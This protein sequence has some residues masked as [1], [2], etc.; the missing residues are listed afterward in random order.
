[1]SAARWVRPRGNDGRRIGQ[2]TALLAGLAFA[3]WS[4]HANPL[5]PKTL[6]IF[7]GWPSTI[8]GTYSVDGAAAELGRY[9]LLVLGDL[10]EKDTHPDH[11]NTVAI[12]AHAALAN[13][14]VFG[15]IDLGTQGLPPAEIDLRCQEWLATGADGVLY[16]EFGYDYGV[17]RAEQNE[18]V[19]FA[20][21]HA[22]DVIANAWV[23]ADVFDTTAHPVH[24]PAGLPGHLGP[25]DYY[26]FESYQ[27]QEGAYVGETFWQ[28][29]ATAL[30]AYRASL[31][32]KALAVTTSLPGDAF[33]RAKF[34]YAWYSASVYAYDGMGWGE[35]L[36]ASDDGQAPYRDPPAI[37]PGTTFLTDVIAESPVYWRGTDAGRIVVDAS[38]HVGFYDPALTTPWMP[39]AWH[40]AIS[41]NPFRDHVVFRAL[42]APADVVVAIRDVTGREIAAV[43]LRSASFSS[44]GV[45][46]A[47]GVPAGIYFFTTRSPGGAGPTGRLIHLN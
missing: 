14:K 44:L 34:D 25:N 19:D 16:D 1:M 42:G 33:D 35:Y 47:R 46:D 45:W 4:A 12:L 26:L 37:E 11:A 24:N 2:G 21:G 30:E 41:P 22:L 10:L 18:A 40:L 28:A 9:D 17:T 8:N 39:P 7:Y 13:T 32:T 5:A 15:Y 3:G 43:P 6:L 36:F 29:K 27:I 23:P 38:T 31:G 20:H